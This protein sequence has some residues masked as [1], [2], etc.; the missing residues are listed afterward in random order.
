MAIANYFY[1]QTTRKY[2]ALFGTYFNQLKVCRTDSG[3]NVVH[4]FIVP[5]SYAPY[6]KVLARVTQDPNIDRKSAITLPRMS[7]EINNITYDSTR[8]ISPTRKIRKIAADPDTGSRNFLYAGAPYNFNFSLYIMSKYNEDAIQL[9]EQ[10]VPFFQPDM[11]NTITLIPGMDPLDIPLILNSV[12][13]EEIYE[14]SFEER[15]AIMW[16]LEFEMKGWFFG[17]E[18]EKKVIKFVDTDLATNT[19][20]NAEFEE[21]ISIQPGLTS[22]GQPTSLLSETIPYNNIEYDDD[23]GIIK[24][25]EQPSAQEMVVTLN[26]SLMTSN[27]ATINVDDSGTYFSVDWGDGTN[28]LTEL[29]DGVSNTNISHVYTSSG[30]YDVKIKFVDAQIRF[31]DSV[32]DVKRWGTNS[33][34]TA[35]SMFK[36]NENLITFTA[37][38]YP[39]FQPG[40]STASMFE[41]C[42][43]FTGAGS[44]LGD[45]DLSNVTN[46]TDMFKNTG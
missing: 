35:E 32:V 34:I 18:R 31:D 38:D 46:T 16:T 24:N 28:E 44:N 43:S 23:Y 26:Q 40:A 27:T 11:T 10:I 30:T 36:G 19:E 25:I 9:V 21:N 15:Q 39:L 12:T 17:P 41:D 7:F 13:S 4:D 33:F 29:A 6:Q 42:T 8:K 37:P 22:Q 5:I 45:W 1:N 14:G 2:V 20:L 3:G